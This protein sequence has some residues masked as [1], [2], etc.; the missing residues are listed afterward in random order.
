MILALEIAGGWLLLSVFAGLFLG[1]LLAA[2][3]GRDEDAAPD[4]VPER[5]RRAGL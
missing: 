5:A 2:C 4:D 1:R 3:G